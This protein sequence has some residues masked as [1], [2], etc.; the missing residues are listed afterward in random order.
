MFKIHP[1][2]QTPVHACSFSCLTA[3]PCSWK[4][5]AADRK[6][7]FRL[8]LTDQQEGYAGKTKLVASLC[9]YLSDC[10]LLTK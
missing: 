5:S 8:L 4:V 7:T 2:C 10:A 9:K 1:K 6:T 3:L